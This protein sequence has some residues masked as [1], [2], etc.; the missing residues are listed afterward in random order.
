MKLRP[1]QRVFDIYTNETGTVV[2]VNDD[3][4]RVQVDHGKFKVTGCPSWYRLIQS[5]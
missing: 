3:T 2:W 4:G 5:E 1:G